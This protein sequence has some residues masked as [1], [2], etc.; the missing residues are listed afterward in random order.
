MDHPATEPRAA[1]PGWKVAAI[2]AGAVLAAGLVAGWRELW[3]LTDDA[4]ISFR[5]AANHRHGWGYTWNP[6]PFA[7]VE[8]YSNFLWMVIL[9]GIWVLSG[10][11]PP[12]TANGL[13]L[14]FAAAAIVLAV[15][16]TA[17]MRLSPALEP[18]RFALAVLVALSAVTSRTFLT[19]AS[20]GL[21]TALFGCLVMA[22]IDGLLDHG[23]TGARASLFRVSGA[24]T[25][26][27]LTRPD[28][29]V[30]VA[31]TVAYLAWRGR[32][33]LPAAL[34][35]LVVPAHLLWRR[36]TYGSWVPNTY[37]AKQV[38]SWPRMGTLY[39]ASY[40][41]EQACW[42]LVALGFLALARF[43]RRPRLSAPVLVIGAVLAA[44]AAYFTF[45]VGGDH[46]EYRV[47]AHLVL[48]G[49][50]L[51]VALAARL[52]LSA[53]AA[54]AALALNLLLALP[55]P[56][57]HHAQTAALG[58]QTGEVPDWVPIAEAF[59]AVARPYVRAFDQLQHRLLEHLVCVRRHT[60]EA[61]WRRRL[62]RFP[63]R[64]SGERVRWNERAVLPEWAV[65][66]AG[67]MLP[68][69]A[70][71]DGYGLT[72]PV[73]AR[74]PPTA[75]SLEFRRLAHDRR[76]PPG[77]FACFDPNVTITDRRV[78]VRPRPLGDQRI[79]DCQA[80]AWPAAA[81]VER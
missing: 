41:F 44:H 38:G 10:R 80:R 27:A 81:R 76:P 72:D 65:G 24:A 64:D 62:A 48:P 16:I 9:E 50:L 31:G 68:E 6:P 1:H 23:R 55:I 28:G 4:Y 14:L 21:E 54:L 20:S 52:Q 60:H 51:L 74:T 39:A 66:V 5:H 12:Q 63:D 43:W 22:W 37:L 58:K 71:I 17:R 79:Q 2:V 15:R 69:V 11:T 29:L 67:W 35:L 13:S 3:F 70:I 8:G 45:V 34:P 57:M 33:R 53:P 32:G 47:Y 30:L 73:V 56:W 18:H 26:A 25:A 77:Y 61:V 42:P 59:P 75:Q 49:A 19:W 7:P 46:F 40:L 78:T 36:A